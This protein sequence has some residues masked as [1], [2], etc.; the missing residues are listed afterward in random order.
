MH[1]QFLIE[2]LIQHAGEGRCDLANKLVE[3]SIPDL[4]Q[5]IGFVKGLADLFEISHGHDSADDPDSH[6]D[7][8]PAILGLTDKGVEGFRRLTSEERAPLDRAHN[9]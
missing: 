6:P 4:R 2:K 1:R 5:R 9:L 7:I 8:A 3:F